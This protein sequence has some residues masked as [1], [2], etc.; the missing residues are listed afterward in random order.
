M[1][2]FSSLFRRP[3]QPNSATW[4]P[5][6]ATTKAVGAA[7]R[8]S[9]TRPAG[10]TKS[11]PVSRRNTK[12]RRPTLDLQVFPHRQSCLPACDCPRLLTNLLKFVLIREYSWIP[13][14]G[15]SPRHTHDILC[16]LA[17]PCLHNSSEIVHYFI[18]KV[19]TP[20]IIHSYPGFPDRQWQTSS[21]S[22]ATR[23]AD[24][25]GVRH[26]SACG[27]PCARSGSDKGVAQEAARSRA[28][29]LGDTRGASGASPKSLPRFRRRPDVN[30]SQRLLGEFER[31]QGKSSRKSEIRVTL[32]EHMETLRHSRLHTRPSNH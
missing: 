22:A 32:Y 2:S 6:A 10:D 1:F 19:N 17:L 14:R 5:T 12:A 9:R 24:R 31:D 29:G 26:R 30:L 21:L 20:H 27:R 23:R 8:R 11:A 13:R 28:Y 7:R 3:P 16:I 15:L 18:R 25:G 4:R